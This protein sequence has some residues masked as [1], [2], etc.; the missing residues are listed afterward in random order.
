[1]KL[2]VEALWL[3]TLLSL[4]DS[5]PCGPE[6]RHLNSHTSLPQSHQARLGADCL[7]IRAGEIVLL[8]DELVKIY[9]IVQRHLGCVEGEDLAFGVFWVC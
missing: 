2:Q 3:V 8:A 6:V 7:D 5:L 4:H 1:M 9:I